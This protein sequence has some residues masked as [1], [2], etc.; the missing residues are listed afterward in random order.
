MG[1]ARVCGVGECVKSG[2]EVARTSQPPAMG[3][4][5]PHGIGDVDAAA[6]RLAWAQCVSTRGGVASDA[7]L[8]ARAMPV[9]NVQPR[10]QPTATPAAVA[11]P[12]AAPVVRALGDV[13]PS[14]TQ[15]LVRVW[16][17]QLRRCMRAA[18][19]GKMQAAKKL[20][21]ADLWLNHESHSVAA[22]AAWNW[23]FAH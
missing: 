3:S 7:E 6:Q 12:D 18:R 2:A 4:A 11:A 23:T 21:P 5:D 8:L 20:R 16:R 10:T 15:R 13:V 9:A 14:H 1:T 17:R 22:T 19:A